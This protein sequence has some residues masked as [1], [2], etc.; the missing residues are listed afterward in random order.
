M[1]I[2]PGRPSSGRVH[3]P[4]IRVS[5]RTVLPATRSLL[6]PMLLPH[7]APSV[8]VAICCRRVLLPPCAA[9][10]TPRSNLSKTNAWR[11]DCICHCTKMNLVA[12]DNTR[13]CHS[14]WKL[15]FIAQN[16]NLD[17]ASIN[18]RNAL[19]IYSSPAGTTTGAATRRALFYSYS[20]GNT[21]FALRIPIPAEC[22]RG[23]SPLISSSFF[24]TRS[25]LQRCQSPL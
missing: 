7:A 21:L 6:H 5:I 12:R 17:A 10:T 11:S 15:D 23:R 2:A 8:A 19:K 25:G 18:A 24:D 9:A 14:P 22:S 4:R 20:S 1:S 13:L 16:R 3:I